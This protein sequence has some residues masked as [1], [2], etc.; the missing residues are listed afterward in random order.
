MAR[1]LSFGS[2]KT[3][4]L[5]VAVQSSAWRAYSSLHHLKLSKPRALS[6]IALKFAT[7]QMHLTA[8][9]I[10]AVQALTSRSKAEAE[11]NHERGWQQVECHSTAFVPL[12]HMHS[13][14]KSYQ[15]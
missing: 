1:S 10:R 14:G 3:S 5:E 9:L 2:R 7:A 12:M 8:F 15:H 13:R 6:T 4:D 11:C